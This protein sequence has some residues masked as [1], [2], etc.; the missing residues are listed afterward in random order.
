MFERQ[1]TNMNNFEF[2][3]SYTGDN[4]INYN[5]I[6]I[7]MIQQN[8]AQDMNM[9]SD[10]CT[11]PINECPRERCIHRTI[12]HEVPHVC[13]IKTRIINHHVY[14]HTYRPEYSCCEENVVSNIQCGSCSQFQ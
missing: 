2:D 14:R 1:D 12:M 11:S 9:M 4:G 13:P 3:N 7:N 10:C 5:N 8:E 6:D